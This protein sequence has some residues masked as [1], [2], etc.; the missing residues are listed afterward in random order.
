MG[1]RWDAVGTALVMDITPGFGPSPGNLTAVGNG[2]ALFTAFDTAHGWELWVTD[3]SAA[4]TAL[5]MDINPGSLNSSPTGLVAVGDGT[6]LFAADDGTHGYELWRSD[7]TAAGT[8]IVGTAASGTSFGFG[9]M[10]LA[11]AASGAAAAPLGS[12]SYYRSNTGLSL[13][14]T[15]AAPPTLYSQK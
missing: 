13:L 15:G 8:S 12:G 7:G 1:N 11:A 3:G 6:A 10:T 5:V 14:L 9:D 4:G 2:T